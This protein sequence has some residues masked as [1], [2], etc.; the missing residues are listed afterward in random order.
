MGI[1]VPW[2][3]QSVSGAF[4]ETQ[5][6]GCYRRVPKRRPTWEL[7]FVGQHIQQIACLADTD[8]SLQPLVGFTCWSWRQSHHWSQ[9]KQGD[10]LGARSFF[11]LQRQT[12]APVTGCCSHFQAP[13]RS[14]PCF[15]WT[16][17]PTSQF[18]VIMHL[19]QG[20]ERLASCF[21]YTLK[22]YPGCTSRWGCGVC[23]FFPTLPSFG[24]NVCGQ[25]RSGGAFQQSPIWTIRDPGLQDTASRI[26]GHPFPKFTFSS[27]LMAFLNG[28]WCSGLNPWLPLPLEAGYNEQKVVRKTVWERS[29]TYSPFIVKIK[30][31]WKTTVSRCSS[32]WRMN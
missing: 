7:C 24:K 11:F 28:S 3:E 19:I 2:G 15:S 12:F 22:L 18:L 4:P 25:R 6:S 5:Q 1:L 14:E 10:Q 32:E 21:R 30:Y 20:S 31:H 27:S 13:A 9:W 8:W 23:W 17:T 16:W 29:L 26:P